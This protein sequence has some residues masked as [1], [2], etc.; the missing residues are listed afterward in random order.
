MEY[1]LVM[2]LSGTTMTCL[3]LLMRCL[4]RKKLSAGMY[5]VL[6]KAAVL[7]YLI[8]LPF[9]KGWYL[10]VI[11][12][13]VFE[14]RIGH[15][16]IPLSLTKHTVLASGDLHIN[17]YAVIQ[18]ALAIVW[19]SGAC[20][21]LLRKLIAYLRITRTFAGY[22]EMKMTDRERAFVDSLREEYGVRRR[23]SF[24]PAQNGE[25]TFT[26]GIH[27]PIIIC[28]RET[29]SREAEIL[30][31]HEMVHIKRLDVLWKILIE[32]TTFLHWWN[33]FLWKLYRDFEAVCECSCDETV[34][35]GKT[36]GEVKEYLRLMIEEAREKKPE[37]NA[38]R[39]KFGFGSNTK[40]IRERM[41][42]LMRKN[43]WNRYVA[44]ALAATLIFANS[45]T[46][47]AYRDG[48]SEIMPEDVSQEEIVK[49]INSD[50]A[51]FTFIGT[52]T[53]NTEDY[54]MKPEI[55][56]LYE[57]Q[58]TDEEGN[59][60]PVFDEEGASTYCNHVYEPGTIQYH[61]K[62]SGGG[63]EVNEY[64]ADRCIR[65]G[66]VIRGDWIS[67]TTFAKCPH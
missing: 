52:N 39:W 36:E 4:L 66:Q 23:V 27:R 19:L 60:Y 1:L 34:M 24:I 49:T 38:V 43:K 50:T 61:L 54:S 28:G 53:E 62:L 48:F 32:F 8:P 22:A 15:D 26:F 57:K 2:A 14:R 13:K 12:T 51:V 45:M 30:A 65:C 64:Y 29:E 46:V 9:L 67:T 47:F 25:P 44:G 5:Y 16:R 10:D 58:F 6:A 17:T 21:L 11:P 35:S 3:Y 56:F 41:D 63:C 40:D 31:R 37:E 18:M 20:V 55:E 33:P 7:Y 59:V 42:N